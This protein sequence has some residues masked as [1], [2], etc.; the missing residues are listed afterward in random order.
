MSTVFCVVW[1][2]HDAVHIAHISFGILA[3][4]RGARRSPAAIRLVG[5]LEPPM[6]PGRRIVMYAKCDAGRT[7]TRTIFLSRSSGA[8]YGGAPAVPSRVEL[9]GRP[10]SLASSAVPVV[11]ANYRG[12]LRRIA[13]AVLYTD[14]RDV[15][16]FRRHEIGI[17]VDWL[18]PP[19]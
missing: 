11:C 12:N 5:N 2:R 4:R 18:V 6:Q 17:R 3:L 9:R 1:C 10:C 16:P 15:S 14:G 13:G 8:L 19:I 7:S